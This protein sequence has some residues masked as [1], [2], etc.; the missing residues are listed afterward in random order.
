MR[1]D[2]SL[3]IY[4]DDGSITAVH[5]QGRHADGKPTSLFGRDWRVTK[6]RKRDGGLLAV[7]RPVERD[8]PIMCTGCGGFDLDQVQRGDPWICRTCGGRKLVP[9]HDQHGEPVQTGS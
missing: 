6:I 4:A 2:T 7:L 3:G 5:L 8:G 9:P 1:R